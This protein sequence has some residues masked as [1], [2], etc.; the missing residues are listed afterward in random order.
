MRPDQSAGGLPLGAIIVMGVSG[1]GK[2]TLAQALAGRIGCPFLEGDSFHSD[3]A[4]AQ[5]RSGRPLQDLDRWPWLD[6]LGH[7]T[8]QAVRADG[9]VAVACSALRRAYRSRLREA[10]AVATRFVLLDAEPAVIAQRIARREQHYMP[11]SLLTS[12]FATLE[13]P[14][15]DENALVLDALR[16]VESLCAEVIAWM[17]CQP[18][19]ADVTTSA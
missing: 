2:S 12:Q 3:E 1:S 8:G 11:A 10:A 18:A 4:V 15:P 13:A 16:P 14:A 19:N 7:A 5:M 17:R 6:R 9:R